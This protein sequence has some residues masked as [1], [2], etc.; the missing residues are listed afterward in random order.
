MLQAGR[1]YD[2]VLGADLTYRPDILRPLAEL[3]G[4]L[5]DAFPHLAILIAAPIRSD[6]FSQFTTFCQDHLKFKVAELPC[7]IPNGLRN[8]GFC[9]SV[10]TEIKIVS[11]ERWL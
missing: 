7:E 6:T 2:L 11:L 8:S 5:K 3:L 9:H 4:R 10:A 1:R